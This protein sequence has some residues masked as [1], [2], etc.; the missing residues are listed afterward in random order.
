RRAAGPA[1]PHPVV[2]RL[3]GDLHVVDVAF[4]LARS[5]DLHELRLPAHLLDARAADVT[6]GRAQSPGE[7]VHHAAQRPAVR[8][9]AL[10][11]FGHQ[12]VGF[13]G[14][15]EVAVLAA[16]LHRAQRT[17]AAIALVAAA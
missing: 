4:A 7:L 12:L 13:A 8:H 6:H 17:H 3:L 1:S 2:R 11:A 5:R 16:L 10:D 9:P 15:L 14:V